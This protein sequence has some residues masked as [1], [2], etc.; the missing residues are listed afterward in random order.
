MAA[1]TGVWIVPLRGKR[2]VGE[3]AIYVE[4]GPAP[5]TMLLRERRRSRSGKHKSP[6]R[7]GDREY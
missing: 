4:K 5:A 6:G 1:G 2:K 3:T 7:I